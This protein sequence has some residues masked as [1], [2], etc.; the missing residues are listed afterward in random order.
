MAMAAPA[1]P[2]GGG[3]CPHALPSLLSYGTCSSAV[4]DITSA[5]IAEQDL[6]SFVPLFTLAC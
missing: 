2:P 6:K 4:K 1:L 5:K 3:S